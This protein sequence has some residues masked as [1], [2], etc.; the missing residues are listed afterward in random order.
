M[1]LFFPLQLEPGSLGFE[2]V[3]QKP[4]EFGRFF[5]QYIRENLSGLGL[6]FTP[7]IMPIA[8]YMVTIE[9]PP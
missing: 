8:A 4:P 5:Y 6:Y 7:E 2:L 9:E 1:M 3:K